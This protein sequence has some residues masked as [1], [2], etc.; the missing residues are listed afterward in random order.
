LRFCGKSFRVFERERLDDVHWKQGCF[1]RDAVGDWWLCLPVDVSIEQT[2]APKDSV[3]IDLGLK[4]VAVTSEGDRLEALC[5]YRDAQHRLG[6]LQRRGHLRQAK[7]LHR[8]IRRRR[9]A[10]A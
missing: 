5:F 1:A 3:G 10:A 6:E 9:Q 8:T 4:D 2:A 7:R